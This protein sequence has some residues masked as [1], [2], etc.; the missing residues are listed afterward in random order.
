MRGFVNG[1]SQLDKNFPDIATQLGMPFG[2]E[3]GADHKALYV[4][5]L[6]GFDLI[7]TGNT[8]PGYAMV[9]NEGVGDSEIDLIRANSDRVI[10]SAVRS[11]HYWRTAILEAMSAARRRHAVLKSGIEWVRGIDSVLATALSHLGM[12]KF[13]LECA[14]LAMYW[15]LEQEAGKAVTAIPDRHLDSL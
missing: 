9:F 13:P 10:E 12:R 7:A 15:Q 14:A 4:Q 6:V 1:P 3:P 8:Y 11:H 5:L 2:Q